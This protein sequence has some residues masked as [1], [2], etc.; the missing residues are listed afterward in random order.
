[1][2]LLLSQ[3]IKSDTFN[4]TK[5]IDFDKYEKIF[6]NNLYLNEF[7]IVIKIPCVSIEKECENNEIKIEKFDLGKYNYLVSY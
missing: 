4:T 2:P 3:T 5:F 1:M 6:Y 7:K